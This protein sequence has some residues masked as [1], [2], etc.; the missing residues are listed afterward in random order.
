[1]CR[2]KVPSSESIA[3]VQVYLNICKIMK[4]KGKEEKIFLFLPSDWRVS[5]LYS[6]SGVPLLIAVPSETWIGCQAKSPQRKSFAP[7]SPAA[8]WARHKCTPPHV[9]LTASAEAWQNW[10]GSSQQASVCKVCWNLHFWKLS[11]WHYQACLWLRKPQCPADK[12]VRILEAV[13]W[14]A[15]EEWSINVKIQ[16]S[17]AVTVLFFIFF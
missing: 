3:E 17:N 2:L 11:G 8:S 9:P 14:I 15:R 1:M 5:L 12:A 16:I 4:R 6:G 7:S 13:K 10:T